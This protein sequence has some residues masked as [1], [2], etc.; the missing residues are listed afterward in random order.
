MIKIMSRTAVSAGITDP[1]YS[2]GA[3]KIGTISV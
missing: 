1:G 2:Y 3:F